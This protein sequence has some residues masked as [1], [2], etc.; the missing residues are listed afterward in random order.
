ME[1]VRGVGT[2]ANL[3]IDVS[4]Q[5]TPEGASPFRTLVVVVGDSLSE[6]ARREYGDARLWTGIF[7]ANREQLKS[8]DLIRP[9]QTLRLPSAPLPSPA[10]C[11]TRARGGR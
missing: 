4:I 10:T 3:Q 6:I 1:S 11:V 8:P 5:A 7:E 9:G 2:A